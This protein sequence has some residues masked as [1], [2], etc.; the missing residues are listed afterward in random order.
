VTKTISA[1]VPT[2]GRAESLGA[3]LESLLQQRIRPG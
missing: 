3:L 1:I 2:V